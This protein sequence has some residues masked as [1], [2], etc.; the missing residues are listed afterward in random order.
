MFV[1]GVWGLFSGTL[2]SLLF[3]GPG[4]FTIEGRSARVIG[5][6][7]ML[8]LPAAFASGFLLA[9]LFGEY[10]APIALIMEI[11]FTVVIGAGCW[12]A[13][14][15]LQTPFAASPKSDDA[16]AEKTLEDNKQA[17]SKAQQSLFALAIAIGITNF[18]LIAALVAFP[19]AFLVAT[20]ALKFTEARHLDARY[21][22]DLNLIR[23]L[24]GSLMAFYIL[25]MVGVI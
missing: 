6:A 13:T 11:G 19:V 2:P 7:L 25:I 22:K 9:W 18:I 21:R 5:A 12:I 23:V 15:K 1:T 10:G 4:K 24:A 3:G 14:R 16:I 17:M 8:P 20:Q